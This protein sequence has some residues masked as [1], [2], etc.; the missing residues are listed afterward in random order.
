MKYSSRIYVAGHTGLI[1]S[2]ITE[3]LRELGYTNLLLPLR[4]ELD[5]TDSAAVAQFFRSHQPEYVFLAAARVGGI[6]ANSTLPAEFVLQN[7]LIQTHVIHEAWRSGVARLLFLGSSCIYPRLAEQPIREDALLT[8]PLELTNRPYAVA[9]IAGIEMCWAYNRQYGTRFLAVMPCNLYGPRDSYDPQLSHFV[10]ALI[11]RMHEAKVVGQK[12]VSVWGTGL[13]RRELLYSKDAAEACI[14]L[15]CLPDATFTQVLASDVQPP[16]VNIGAGTDLTVLEVAQEIAKAV[17]FSG[18]L[19]TDPSQPDGTPR[20]LLDISRIN[21]LGWTPST[22]FKTG[23][24]HSYQDFQ[25][26]FC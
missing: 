25:S 4:S 14:F 2:A 8:G 18:K 6:K 5:L 7:L 15:M 20:K 1:G 12:E 13:P 23:L 10:P 26:R 9:K 17:G 21:A 16:T 3:R 24:Q 19:T 11:R 22:P